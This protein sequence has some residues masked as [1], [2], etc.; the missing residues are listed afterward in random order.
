MKPQ[1]KC[2]HAGCNTLVDYNV[3]Y[4]KKHEATSKKQLYKDRFSESNEK[5]HKFYKTKRWERT[6]KQFRLKNPLCIECLAN[7]IVRKADVVDHIV[8]LKDDWDKRLDWD[9]L[10]SLCHE[11]HNIKTAKAR[12]IR[13]TFR[14]GGNP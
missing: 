3:S 12:Q 5:F 13:G 11:H 9:N 6:S 10:Q 2:N 14:K 8:E 1:K 4:C 7:G